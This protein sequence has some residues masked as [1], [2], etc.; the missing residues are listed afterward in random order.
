MTGQQYSKTCNKCK[1]EIIM[2]N[3]GGV[4]K[5]LNKDFTPHKC[6]GDSQDKKEPG[7]IIGLLTGYNISSATF[8]VKGSKTPKTYAITGS[9]SKAWQDARFLSPQDNHPDIWL[10]FTLDSRNFVQ[11][12]YHV[13]QAPAWAAELKDPTGGEIKSPNTHNPAPCTTEQPKQETTCISPAGITPSFV[14]PPSDE[15]RIR[16]VMERLNPS[17]RVGCRISLAGMVN[18]VIEIKKTHGKPIDTEEVKREA[19]ALFLWCD[20]LTTRVVQ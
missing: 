7:T 13:V 1:Q 9:I 15:D 11:P 16:A 5:A 20:G 4:W 2:Q 6:S 17:D 8:Y 3:A 19:V 10:E 18:S 12:G 14:P